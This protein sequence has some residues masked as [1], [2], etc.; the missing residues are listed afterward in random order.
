MISFLTI[1]AILGLSAGIAP[2][3]L[4]ALIIS[5]TLRYDIKSGI[6]IALAPVITDAPI[7]AL[8]LMLSASLS[9][10]SFLLGVIS[11]AGAVFI[12]YLGI[13]SI[14]T[15]GTVVEID[16]T[17]S[18]SFK[19][20]IF[21]NALSPHPYLFWFTVGAPIMTKALQQS[22][23]CVVS[24]IAGFYL[25]LVGSKIILAV[26]TGKSRTFMS[27]SAYILIMRVLGMILC[28]FAGILFRDSLRYIGIL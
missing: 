8:T 23:A 24:F 9:E 25:L 19:K 1:G 11:F 20:G 10:F 22:T 17:P 16:T 4:L 21:V 7:I 12:F 15:K 13:D 2:G 28:I 27:G 6:K 3:P 18:S 5:E 14:R 26:I